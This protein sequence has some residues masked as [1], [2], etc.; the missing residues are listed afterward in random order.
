MPLDPGPPRYLCGEMNTASID[1]SASSCGFMS[2]C[3]Y[4]ALAA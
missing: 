4:G 3:T 2:I 1:A